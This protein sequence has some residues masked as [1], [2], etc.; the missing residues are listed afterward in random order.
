MYDWANSAFAT[1]IMAAVLPIYYSQVAGATLP[2]EAVATAY[3]SLGLS[4]SLLIVAVLSPILGTISDV[5]RGKKP[6]L[7]VFAALGIVGTGLLILVDTGDW[8]LASL[9]FVV[10]RV[11][12]SGANVFYDSLLPH[13]AME[14]EQDR[15]STR[16]YAHGISGW[17]C[18]AGYQC[19]DDPVSARQLGRASEFCQCC[20]LVGAVFDSDP[21]PGSRTTSGNSHPRASVKCDLRQFSSFAMKC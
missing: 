16:G 5:V 6:F 18:A 2:S 17:R 9:L 1:T 7:T 8:L 20:C 21:P 12:F 11:G 14:D 4:V 15:V 3:W 19:C 10:A 13:V